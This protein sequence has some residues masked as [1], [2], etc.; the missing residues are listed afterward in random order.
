[1][2]KVLDN[3][4]KLKSDLEKEILDIEERQLLPMQIGEE[5]FIFTGKLEGKIEAKKYDLIRIDQVICNIL[6]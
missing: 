4:Y 6:K 5:G 1:M 2:K 3:L